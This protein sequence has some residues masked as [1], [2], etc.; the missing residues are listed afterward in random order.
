M[1]AAVPPPPHGLRFS[2]RHFYPLAATVVAIA[3]FNLAW[4]LGSE[5]VSE[6]D[7]S[8][9]A[10][11]AWEMATSGQWIGTTF[12]GHLDYYNVKPPL[13]VWLIALTF[14]TF[15]VNLVSLRIVSAVASCCTV[16]VLQL[17]GRRVLQ[18]AA[19]ALVAGIVLST[20]F[21]FVYVHAGRSGNTDSL[22]TLLILWT[23]VILWAAQDRAWN[24]VWLGP[25]LAAAF[26]LKGMGVLMPA[27]IVAA[28]ETWR[29][30]QGRRRTWM[31]ALCGVAL[32]IV[33]VGAWVWARWQLDRSNLFE[34][35]FFYD[36]VA[37]TSTPLEGHYG[38]VLYYANVLQKYHYDWLIGAAAGLFAAGATWRGVKARLQAATGETKILLCAWAAATVLIPTVMRTKNPWYLQPFYP[39]YALAIGWLISCA[40]DI[41][42]PRR[43]TLRP[44][45]VLLACI[46][47]FGVAEGR[48]IAYSHWRRDIDQ[49]AQGVLL[50]ERHRL[51]SHRI[52]RLRWNY[53][54][55]FVVRALAG[56]EHLVVA[57]FSSLSSHIKPGDFYL[58]PTP[59]T[60][61]GFVLVRSNGTAW[62]YQR[63]QTAECTDTR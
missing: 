33:P 54:D 9:Y 49:S 13:N 53:A 63:C 57:D 38:G 27:T 2:D 17:W 32:F 50:A 31:P 37:G 47:V 51:T 16:F 25:T 8:L 40:Y 3:A 5:V 6:W 55:I 35:L 39:L 10:M 41:A 46:V 22:F 12:L 19:A 21:A 23:V 58:S 62:L 56:A 7:E 29:S 36:F 59:L 45:L 24:I 11:S 15:G 18:S 44:A 52:Y 61:D 26:L 20:S 43:D 60:F 30:M 4:R 48:L 28:V 14:K 34:K 42:R 1:I